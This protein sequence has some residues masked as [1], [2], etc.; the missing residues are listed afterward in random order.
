MQK[1]LQEKLLTSIRYNQ[2]RLVSK[3]RAVEAEGPIKRLLGMNEFTLSLSFLTVFG[4]IIFS[5]TFTFRTFFLYLVM[6]NEF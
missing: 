2:K 3:Q 6:I 1:N 5:L 4:I